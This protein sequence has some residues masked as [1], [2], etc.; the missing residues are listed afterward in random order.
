M[1]ENEECVLRV[2]SSVALFINLGRRLISSECQQG[3][4][5]RRDPVTPL[6]ISTVFT[7]YFREFREKHEKCSLYVVLVSVLVCSGFR[8]KA[9]QTKCLK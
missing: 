9:P 3:S 6:L 5:C 2:G 1:A 7:N 8:Y 4:R